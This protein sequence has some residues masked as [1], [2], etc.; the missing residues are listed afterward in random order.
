LGREDSDSRSELNHDFNQTKMRLLA[1][2]S[3]ID[4]RTTI[5]TH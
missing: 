1:V 5:Y 4:S 2:L 3:E